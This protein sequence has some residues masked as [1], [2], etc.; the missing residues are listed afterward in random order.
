MKN[1]VQAHRNGGTNRPSPQAETPT[2]QKPVPQA[3]L[4]F[5]DDAGGIFADFELP[6]SAYAAM[7]RDA[8]AQG[9][10]MQAWIEAA[11]RSH[12]AKTQDD[13]QW[14][15]DLEDAVLR[16][17]GLVNLI[18]DKLDHLSRTGDEC[19][20]VGYQAEHYVAA[21]E[22]LAR[23]NLTILH[24]AYDKAHASRRVSTVARQTEVA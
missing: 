10:T 21:V 1:T 4:Q 20:F 15:I 16:I 24:R 11:V 5:K 17:D 6:L 13:G 9:M 14:D 23:D 7:A 8:K 18:V 12:A 22:L 3:R 2:G 19:M